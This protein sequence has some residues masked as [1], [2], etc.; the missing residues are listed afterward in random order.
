MPKI[1]NLRLANMLAGVSTETVQFD[2]EGIGHIESPE[3]HAELLTLANFF[4]V[5]E[6]KVEEP[7]EEPVVK[8]TTKK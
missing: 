5:E 8:K 1:Q 2:H 7:K 4:P 3:L 6:P